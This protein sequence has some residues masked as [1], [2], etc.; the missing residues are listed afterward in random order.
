MSEQEKIPQGWTRKSETDRARTYKAPFVVALAAAVA[1]G[2][3]YFFRPRVQEAELFGA[4]EAAEEKVFQAKRDA[5]K[6][7]FQAA[8][9]AEDRVLKANLDAEDRVLKANLDAM[10]GEW[11]IEDKDLLRDIPSVKASVTVDEALKK[12]VSE[13]EMLEKVELKLRSFGINVDSKSSEN[14]DVKVACRVVAHSGDSKVRLLSFYVGG[15]IR[16]MM[17][18]DTRLRKP[19][20]PANRAYWQWGYIWDK[21]WLGSASQLEARDYIVEG[22]TKVAEAFAN[23]YLAAN[24][25]R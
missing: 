9:D 3:L 8:R 19:K 21:G 20:P 2:G 14:L 15:K 22:I 11:L 16:T 10:E 7:V 23:D 24:P 6:K 25:K 12:I 13:Q 1:F 5:L 18:R 4:K 17:R